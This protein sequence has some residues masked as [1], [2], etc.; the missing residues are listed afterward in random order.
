MFKSPEYIPSLPERITTGSRLK[1]GC[2]LSYKGK[3]LAPDTGPAASSYHC[4][5][6]NVAISHLGWSGWILGKFFRRNDEILQQ[7]AQGSGGVT[8]LGGVQ[9]T[10]RCGTEGRVSVGMVGMG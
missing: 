1:N 7:A 4:R 3:N 5:L 8:V 6:K 10:Q 2:T 9:E